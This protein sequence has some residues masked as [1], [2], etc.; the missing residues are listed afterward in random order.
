MNLSAKEKRALTTA[1]ELTKKLDNKF[2][3]VFENGGTS[4]GIIGSKKVK[5]EDGWVFTNE[6]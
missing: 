5:F 6:G 2:F 1:H 4:Y 3:H